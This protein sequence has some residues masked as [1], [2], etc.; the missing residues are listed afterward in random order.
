MPL[1]RGLFV[2]EAWIF[3]DHPLDFFP[4]IN[5]T[6]AQGEDHYLL[7]MDQTTGDV[8]FATDYDGSLDANAFLSTV[9]ARMVNA[10][11][12]LHKHLLVTDRHWDSPAKRPLTWQIDLQCL[13]GVPVM[14][15]ALQHL[16][17][18][19]LEELTRRGKNRSTEFKC[20]GLRVEDAVLSLENGSQERYVY[21]YR[22]S[23]DAAALSDELLATVEATCQAKNRE[24]AVQS[25]AADGAESVAAIIPA[26]DH[27][28]WQ[29]SQK[30]LRKESSRK[31]GE[32]AVWAV[33]DELFEQ[34]T[35][36]LGCFALRSNV[37][38]DPWEALR[39]HVQHGVIE[40][41]FRQIN[42]VMGGKETD[43]GRLF[44]YTL[45]QAIR[46]QMLVAAKRNTTGDLTLLGGSLPKALKLLNRVQARRHCSTTAFML[47]EISAQGQEIFKLLDLETKLPSTWYRFRI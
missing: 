4:I 23:A 13:H 33:D 26:L 17:D 7:V 15:D 3:I 19:H 40:E 28:A 16:F 43:R 45:A 8:V 12:P 10:G 24:E 18:Q 34:E 21:L 14:D 38:L 46:L 47:E 2:T 6:G 37:P 1:G 22:H 20:N 36:M 31:A 35:R 25:M 11:L 44:A 9:Y 29:R 5:T 41:G 27:E 39:L 42:S 32:A 30:F